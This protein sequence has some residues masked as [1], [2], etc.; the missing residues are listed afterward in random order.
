MTA[1][2]RTLNTRYPYCRCV[3]TR[4]WQLDIGAGNICPRCNKLILLEEDNNDSELPS[5]T[6]SSIHTNSSSFTDDDSEMQEMDWDNLFLLLQERVDVPFKISPFSGKSDEDIDSLLNKFDAYCEQHDKDNEYKTRRI[7]FL[8]TGQAYKI[9]KN[10]TD[11][12][13]ANYVAVCRELQL[14][15]G[16]LTLPPE[17]AYPQLSKLKMTNG[18]KVQSFYEE[19]TSMGAAPEVTLQMLKAF[20]RRTVQTY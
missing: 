7:P 14:N 17:I 15:F 12:V 10:F 16:P 4:T 6:S 3:R 11:E 8:L 19:L 18:T 20:F 2:R 13:K 1:N 5:N 9:Y